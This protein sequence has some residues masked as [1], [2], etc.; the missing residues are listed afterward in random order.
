MDEAY[1]FLSPKL[2]TLYEM[3]VKKNI[4]ELPEAV[5][6]KRKKT[7]KKLT[8][9]ELAAIRGYEEMKNDLPLEPA[10]RRRGVVDFMEDY[11]ME[12]DDE[13]DDDDEQEDDAEDKVKPAKKRKKVKQQ[14][15]EDND[16]NEKE[17][18]VPKKSVKQKKDKK[19]QAVKKSKVKDVHD[20]EF[21][22]D[23]DDDDAEEPKKSL[24]KKKEKKK[25]DAKKTKVKKV[26][27]EKEDEEDEDED[28]A[29]KV[30]KMDAV[31]EYEQAIAAENMP[32]S[33]DERDDNYDPPSEMEEKDPDHE[34]P[35]IVKRGKAKQEK[36]E[37]K[38]ISKDK[39][40][41]QQE[42]KILSEEELKQRELKAFR[43]CEERFCPLLE[44]WHKLLASKDVDGLQSLLSK[45]LPLVN[46]FSA[47]FIEAFD[48]STLLKETKTELKSKNAKLERCS[49][50]REAFRSSYSSK[51]DQLPKTLK[52]R[53]NVEIGKDVPNS[54]KALDKLKTDGPPT[55]VAAKDETRSVGK[56][57]PRK[58]TDPT[59][60]RKEVSLDPRT[61]SPKPPAKKK[62]F[63]L[64][65]LMRQ[66]RV[67]SEVDGAKES[68]TLGAPK[69]LLIL[70]SWMTEE[71]QA[72]AALE[73]PRALAL[74][75]LLD[76]AAF[77]PSSK[78]NKDSIARSIEAAI[79]NEAR[80]LS[81]DWIPCYWK[82]VHIIVA[83]ICGKLQPTSLFNLL[84]T[85]RF[86]T[87]D[88]LVGLPEKT[89]M[90]AFEG[91]IV[92]L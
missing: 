52:I 38:V 60:P 67:E 31:E 3:G 9:N 24:K 36:V 8:E 35:K 68:N 80:K 17:Q 74:E 42:T 91:D 33:E 43:R 22:F 12:S 23:V 13:E 78:V 46:D 28:S 27:N 11:E 72:P 40:K 84:V 79:Y 87:A 88:Q 30:D 25:Q 69:K 66:G 77:F 71:I 2:I 21:G 56:P 37:S 34:E 65:N 76:M 54:S 41:K 26:R 86:D 39:K 6:N 45:L 63:S 82:K 70:P 55:T 64:T 5:E 58:E 51:R 83:A 47:I 1:S 19:S 14:S 90:E 29:K 85:G 89:F 75:F 16:V 4:H 20:D 48:I 59:A 49:E 92:V 15:T 50:L 10:E 81:S 61:A 57:L 7:D 62:K 73:D 32:N 44:R 18:E 53:K